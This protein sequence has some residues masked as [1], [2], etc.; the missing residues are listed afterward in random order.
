MPI[1]CPVCE[2]NDNIAKFSAIVMGIGTEP[3]Y[4]TYREVHT[5]REVT[6]R[7]AKMVESVKP[8]DSPTVVHPEGGECG[9]IIG[10]IAILISL[11][12]IGLLLFPPVE[13]DPDV[14]IGLAY[15]FYSL[16]VLVGLLVAG[17]VFVVERHRSPKRKREAAERYA[18]VKQAWEFAS[19][20]WPRMYYCH[21]CGVAF[22]SDT[23]EYCEVESKESLKEFVYSTE[24]N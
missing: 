23:G 10:T 13:G 12:G 4:D 3:Y 19:A 9:C 20:R 17:L 1:V 6:T 18:R 22:D 5:T 15:L 7:L 16:M 14:D 11:A 2:R 8:P 24:P 21:R